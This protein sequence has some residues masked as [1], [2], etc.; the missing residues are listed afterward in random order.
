MLDIQ[1]EEENE[2]KSILALNVQGELDSASFLDFYDYIINKFNKGYALFILDFSELKTLSSAGISVLLRIKNKLEE[3]NSFI[4]FYKV[5]S[6]IYDLFQ[7]LGFH[8]TFLIANNINELTKIL[9]SL[10]ILRKSKANEFVISNRFGIVE[11]EQ[12]KE[13]NL[14]TQTSSKQEVLFSFDAGKIVPNKKTETQKETFFTTTPDFEDI[15]LVEE[16]TTEPFSNLEEKKE[17]D[18]TIPFLSKSNEDTKEIPESILEMAFPSKE[19]FQEVKVNCGNCGTKMR[20]LSQGIHRCPKCK[21]R[22][23]FRQSGSIS[24]IEKLP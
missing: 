19:K 2:E 7:F 5:K 20:I 8:K 13:E 12:T 17:F 18:F 23:S 24:T 10:E 9:E 4:I 3:N 11:E 14:T 15:P 21:S 22:F 6:E 1:I 16:I